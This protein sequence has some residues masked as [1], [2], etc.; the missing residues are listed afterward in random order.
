MLHE[1]GEFTD[2]ERLRK[3]A[4]FAVRMSHGFRAQ[5][6]Y[7]SIS[8]VTDMRVHQGLRKGVDRLTLMLR[9]KPAST[10]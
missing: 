8:R 4:R 3:T 6:E 7:S 10:F 9:P 1:K 5:R 2:L